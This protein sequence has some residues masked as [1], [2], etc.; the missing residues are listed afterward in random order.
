MARRSF[1]LFCIIAH[2]IV[3]VEQNETKPEKKSVISI[4]DDG[5]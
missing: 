2:A 1:H 4:G 3:K 5:L